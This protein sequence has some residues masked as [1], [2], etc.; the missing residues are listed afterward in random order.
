MKYSEKLKHPLWQKKRLQILSRDKFTCKLCKD[1]EA[2]LHVHH[3]Y[4][5]N[6]FEPWDYPNS[7][8]VTLCEHC[9]AEIER[10]KK[11]DPDIPF[12][13]IKIYKS[14]GWTNKSRIMF[15]GDIANKVCSMRIY[16]EDGDFVAGYSMGDWV[17]QE[18][19]KII[20]F[21]LK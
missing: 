17:L 1:T 21:T 13:A 6:S 18:I 16:D 7:A 19:L 4:Y 10:K 20:K 9:H 2:T 11:D 15:I 8:L 5:E 14:T 3:K 12:E